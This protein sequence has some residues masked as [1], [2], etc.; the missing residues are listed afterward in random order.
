MAFSIATRI[1]MYSPFRP[2]FPFPKST[3]RPRHHS[4]HQRSDFR[5]MDYEFGDVLCNAI[6]YALARKVT[7]LDAA[8]LHSFRIMRVTRDARRI[9]T[10]IRA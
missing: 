5:L 6:D 3:F 1:R 7:Y 10:E 9:E 8:Q 2:P 4:R